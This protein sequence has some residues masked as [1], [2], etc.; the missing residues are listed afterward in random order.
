MAESLRD[1]LL[2]QDGAPTLEAEL[3]LLNRLFNLENR[4]TASL[5][6]WTVVVWSSFVAVVIALLI[7]A[8][9]TIEP[10]IPLPPGVE[11]TPAS[12]GD[13]VLLVV[14]LCLLL[15]SVALPAMGTV[16]LILTLRTRRSATIAQLRASIA[17]V[18]AQLKQLEKR[19]TKDAP[20]LDPPSNT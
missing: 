17:V 13:A 11:A 16:L 7:T 6:F 8:P 5:R 2:R 15:A 1:G 12:T 18:D 3:E 19:S 9:R 20:E 10:A 4:R 14:V